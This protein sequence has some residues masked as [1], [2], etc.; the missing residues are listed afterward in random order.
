MDCVEDN[1]LTFNQGVTGSRPVRPTKSGSPP[2][3][4]E[5][6]SETDTGELV[7]E[8]KVEV[9]IINDSHKPVTIKRVGVNYGSWDDEYY[10]LDDIVCQR[11]NLKQDL[12]AGDSQIWAIPMKTIK[13]GIRG[14]PAKYVY[15][16]DG[17]YK[18]TKMTIPKDVLEQ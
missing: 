3:P 15:V 5:F 4:G 2:P 9:M 6:E 10:P 18:R 17:R 11:L 8:E 7:T 14:K 12:S 1:T 16:E 13:G